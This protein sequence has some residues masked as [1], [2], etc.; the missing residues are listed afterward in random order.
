M[1]WAQT[2]GL[3]KVV[4]RMQQFAGNEHAD[5]AFWQPAPLLLEAAATG[6]WPK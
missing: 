1:F 2:R 4:A 5:P 3:D 6:K